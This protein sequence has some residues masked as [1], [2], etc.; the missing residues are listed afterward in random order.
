MEILTRV[1]MGI[2][3]LVL[4]TNVVVQVL[5]K[6]VYSRV[7]TNLLVLLVS[8][9]VTLSYGGLVAQTDEVALTLSTLFGVVIVGF[10]VAFG[11]MFG[12]DKL[13]QMLQQL[14]TMKQEGEKTQ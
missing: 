9:A 7:P 3:V 14:K 5:K 13:Q 11:A 8:Q 10:F 6:V 4:V 2:M 12:F 1:V